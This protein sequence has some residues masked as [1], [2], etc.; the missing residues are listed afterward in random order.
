MGSVIS[1]IKTMKLVLVKIKNPPISYIVTYW[2]DFFVGRIE[3]SISNYYTY[4]WACT[5]WSLFNEWS[6]TTTYKVKTG[7][8]SQFFNILKV[9]LP[10]V[11]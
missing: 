1:G 2:V 11:N 5:G 9:T 7:F 6:M 4:N 8:I 3:R 10:F